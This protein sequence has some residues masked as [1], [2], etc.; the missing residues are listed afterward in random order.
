ML[1]EQIH[2]QCWKSC[3]KHP[4]ASLGIFSYSQVMSYQTRQFSTSLRSFDVTCWH[5]PFPSV[6]FLLSV[7][8]Y[9][10]GSRTHNTGE[11]PLLCPSTPVVTYLPC[12][13]IV[14]YLSLELQSPLPPSTLIFSPSLLF[15][16]K[17]LFYNKLLLRKILQN[18]QGYITWL[19]FQ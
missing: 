14:Q 4:R 10:A 15:L 16:D 13:P 17:S 18:F 12:K 1:I 11:P 9:P 19:S 6:D 2:V 7:L 8:A 5:K 3:S